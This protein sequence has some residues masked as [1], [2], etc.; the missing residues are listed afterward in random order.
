M[1]AGDPDTANDFKVSFSTLYGSK[2]VATL[3]WFYTPSGVSSFST[4]YG[5]KWVAIGCAA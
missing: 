2:W 4:L 1:Q 5:S 3:A